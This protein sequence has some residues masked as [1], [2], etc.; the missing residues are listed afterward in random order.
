MNTNQAKRFNQLLMGALA[1]AGINQEEA[2]IFLN[3][4]DKRSALQEEV[5][6]LL[7]RHCKTP[8]YNPFETEVAPRN[9][10]HSYPRGWQ[11]P[12]IIEQYN[13]L[14][15][16]LPGLEY[17]HVSFGQEPGGNLALVPKIDWLGKILH[18][19]DPYGKDYWR[20]TQHLLGC[21]AKRQK[22]KLPNNFS[23][24]NIGLSLEPRAALRWQALEQSLP[25]NSLLLPLDFGQFH[26]GLSP[27]NA[28][29]HILRANHLPNGSVHTSCLLLSMPGRLQSWEHLFIANSADECVSPYPGDNARSH[30]TGF[31]WHCGLEFGFK[32]AGDA[33]NRWGS[34]FF[35]TSTS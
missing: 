35:Y 18:V 25:G 23:L 16:L 20:I 29:E 7:G 28:R 19:S 33:L 4:L 9:R 27:R 13:C 1:S 32:F 10:L 14:E 8:A 6:K 31:S 34:P 2:A 11:Y 15:A 21:L 12:V 5:S 22:L 17:P 3:D 26:S 24:E 30:C